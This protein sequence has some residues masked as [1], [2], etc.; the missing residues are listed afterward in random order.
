[1]AAR[2]LADLTDAMVVKTRVEACFAAFVTSG[3][4]EPTVGVGQGQ[5]PSGAKLNE[6]APGMVNYLRPGEEVSFAAPSGAGQFEPV[7]M[8]ALLAMAAGAGITYDQLTG[9]LR[10]A[11][12]SS[13][14][15]GKI[16]FRRLVEQLQWLTLIPTAMERIRTRV[17]ETAILAGRLRDRKGGYPA[18]WIPPANEPIDPKK[19]LEAD[20][21]AVRAGR[22]SP[23]EFI[24][25]W[26]RDPRQ[27]LQD[28][29][30][31]WKLADADKLV[32]DIDPRQVSRAGLAQVDPS[33][34]SASTSDAP[35]AASSSGEA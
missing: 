4:A 10:R 25:A 7:M 31:F 20:I 18:Q 8:A 19:D 14:R 35:P 13:L 32:F 6:L 28:F 23:Q 9:D 11:N 30:A 15:A 17:V 2:D 5:D 27:V 21:L 29:K 12:Y 22:M 1:M 3:E 24:A 26:G 34:A 33:V 16:E